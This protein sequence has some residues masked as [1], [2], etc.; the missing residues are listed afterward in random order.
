MQTRADP[1]YDPDRA[2]EAAPAEPHAPSVRSL[3]LALLALLALTCASWGLAHVE[4]GPAGT[5]VAI[6]IAAIK[7][8]IVAVAFME[9]PRAST[10]ARIV[11]L[12]T[13]VFI[14]LLCAGTVADVALR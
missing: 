13:V 11:A 3:V 8:A 1:D 5:P 12:V 7:A 9:L 2:P 6:A 14:A 4:L 10:T